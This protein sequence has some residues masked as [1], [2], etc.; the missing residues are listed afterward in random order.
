MG[1]TVW[2]VVAWLENI[3]PEDRD[4]TTISDG[5]VFNDEE[6]ALHFARGVEIRGGKVA[7]IKR[8]ES[9]SGWFESMEEYRR[10]GSMSLSEISQI[11][12]RGK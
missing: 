11:S 7:C 8:R 12:S 4:S 6:I 9:G 10:L 3:K 5:A 1:V 2:Q